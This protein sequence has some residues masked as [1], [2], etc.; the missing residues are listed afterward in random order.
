MSGCWNKNTFQ[1]H[2]QKLNIVCENNTLSISNATFYGFASLVYN[3]T[4][5]P[6][7]QGS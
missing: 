2:S 5:T 7:E 4:F 1:K 6:T 3:N